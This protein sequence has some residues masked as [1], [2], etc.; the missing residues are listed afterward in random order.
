MI[1][2]LFLGLVTL[3]LSTLWLFNFSAGI[4]GGIWL[5]LTGGFWLVVLGL[6]ISFV[7]PWGYT[8]ATL[9]T[10]LLAVPITKLADGG[11]RILVSILAFILSGYNNFI[12]AVWVSIVFVS[13]MSI[14]GHS[15]IALWLFGYAVVMGPIG[16][17]ASHEDPDS[18]GT[19]LGMIFVQI[20]YFV[21]SISLLFGQSLEAAGMWLW[22]LILIFTGLTSW[23]GFLSVPKKV[24]SEVKLATAYEGEIVPSNQS[25]QCSNCNFMNTQNARYCKECGKELI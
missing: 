18:M 6:I 12:L 20:S 16:Y 25:Y 8:I 1:K 7:M 24:E 10:L 15:P 11:H 14:S 22:L 5:A 9:P 17:M 13:L 23:V 19:S 4:I 3:S 2:K 21:M